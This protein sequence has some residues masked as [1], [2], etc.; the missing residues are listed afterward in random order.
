MTPVEGS[1]ILTATA[2][3][4]AEDVAVAEGS[5]VEALMDRAG[6]AIATAV[7]RLAGGRAV[8]VLCGPGNNGGDGYVAA[9][10]L[11]AAGLTVR[12]AASGPPRTEA[13]SRARAAWGGEVVALG[14]AAAAPV[15]VDA[16]F[17][18]GLGRPLAAPVIEALHRLAAE[19][20][21]SIAVDLPSGVAT[22]DGAV[23][24]EP[25]RFAVTLALG[26]AKPSHLL[27]PAARFAGAVRVLDIGVVAHGPTRAL[28]PPVLGAPGPDAHKFARGMVAIVAGAMPGAAALAATAAA[29]TGAGYV[30]ALGSGGAVP[31]AI[32]RRPFAAEA[33]A[34]AR[35]GVVLIGPGLGRDEEARA[36]LGA[37]LASGRALVI[38]GDALHLTQPAALHGHGGT[39]VLTP[40]EGEFRAM[41]GALPGSK[42]DRARAAAS[43]AGAV[44]VYKG[45]DTV[46]AAPG[47]RVCVAGAASGWLST[48]GSGD[49][50]AGAV[51]AMVAGGLDPFDAA[52]A[53]VW[54]HGEAARLCGGSFV[55][56]D[57]AAALSAARASR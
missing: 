9:A 35:F 26:A 53:A 49:V 22:D 25:P 21:L 2:M 20:W 13:A 47:G 44:V 12:V 45:A 33:L 28:A 6:E 11:R 57:L 24:S 41:F 8:L 31:H 30:L 37:S 18:T 1:A 7:Q 27:Q 52:S 42:I 36:R 15:L 43:A 14:E 48:A 55:A 29:R 19:A 46:I 50:L 51:A 23:M 3:R 34:D 40:H 56:D 39:I 4:A 5:S 54:L 38:D 16:L 32:V 10:R 17:G